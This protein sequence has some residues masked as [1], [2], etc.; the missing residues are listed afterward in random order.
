M[1][2]YVLC[3]WLLSF[4]IVHA[5]FGAKY[6]LRVRNGIPDATITNV[7]VDNQQ[8]ETPTATMTSKGSLA[9]GGHWDN[10]VQGS[11]SYAIKATITPKNGT[12]IEVHSFLN[13]LDTKKQIRFVPFRGI[14]IRNGI[15]D[16]TITNVSLGEVT[17]FGRFENMGGNWW[18]NEDLPYK[19]SLDA[20]T[21][22]SNLFYIRMTIKTVDAETG[23]TTY[24]YVQT[25]DI[26]APQ[27]PSSIQIRI[28][29]SQKAYLDKDRTKT[30]GTST[31]S[32]ALT[33]IKEYK[34]PVSTLSA[35]DA[36]YK[37]KE[38]EVMSYDYMAYVDK[39]ESVGRDDAYTQGDEIIRVDLL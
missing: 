23:E 31:K 34:A 19:G 3:T 12:P 21:P 22:R 4:I 37:K 28:V 14:R 39:N 18:P 11:Q 10:T 9:Y 30:I 7:V 35:A 1:K 17:S 2:R 36:E 32:I 29:S 24:Q 5:S 15:P 38:K 25:P 8:S 20:Y 33:S 6:L 13:I 16:S 26:T 27:E